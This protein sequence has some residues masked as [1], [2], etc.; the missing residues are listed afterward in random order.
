MTPSATLQRAVIYHFALVDARRLTAH[1][2]V[3]ED[4]LVELTA[5]ILRDGILRQPVLVD[6]ESGVILD[7]HHRVRA[8]KTLGCSLIPAYLVDY[9]DSGIEVWPRRPGIPVD[10]EGVVKAG[11][12]GLPYPP[13]TTRHEWP[14][15][16]EA[17]PVSLSSLK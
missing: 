15:P 17:R 11:L 1:E 13:K 2:E 7:G 5:E 10:K 6:S 8:L 14:L 9:L 16:P 4:H 12:S 3:D